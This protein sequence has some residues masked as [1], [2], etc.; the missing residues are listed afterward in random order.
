MALVNMITPKIQFCRQ[1]GIDI[2]ESDWP[3]HYAPKRIMGDR[4]ELISVTL[5]KNIIQSLRIDIENASPGRADLKALVERRFGLVPAKFRQFTPGYVEKDFNE[6]GAR[7]Y[8]LDAALDL[9]E[10]TQ[11]L[12]LAVLEHN[13]TPIRDKIIPADMVTDGLSATPLDL[14]QWG[15]INRSG[16][17]RALTIEEVALNVMPTDKARVT[18]K[19]IYFKGSY[20][21]CD[22]ALRNEWYSKARQSGW[23][24]TVSY[25]PRSMDIV[26]LRDSK[27]HRGFEI[28]KLLERSFVNYGKSL[29]EIEELALAKKRNEA[30]SEIDRQSKRILIREKMAEIESNAK[31]NTNEV[32]DSNVPKSLKTSDIRPN[33]AQEKEI[34]RE[35]EVFEFGDRVSS[36]NTDLKETGSNADIN[37][38]VSGNNMLSLLREKRRLREVEND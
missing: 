14:W 18:G 30:S 9:R 12:I 24:V 7:D 3:S 27:L 25:D 16:C 1:Y 19:G 35:A 33:K 32:N 2:D 22:T 36:A 11:L 20:Y 15:I 8:R 23:T 17:L 4:G 28:C 34:Q 5:G 26:Y 10:F 31:R 38:T 13:F 6:R 21:S 29:F 37:R